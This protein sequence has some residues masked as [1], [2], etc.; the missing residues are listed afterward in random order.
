MITVRDLSPDDLPA[1]TAIYEHHTLH[2][3]GTFDEAPLSLDDM[4]G[5]AEK[6]RTQELPWLVAEE[7]GEIAG[8]AYAMLMHD[9][10]CWRFT[11]ENS[12]YVAHGKQRQG[13][14]RM[15]LSEL[16]SRCEALGYRQMIAAIGDSGNQGSIGLHFEM[17]FEFAGIYRAV[18]FKFG[19]WL[20][21]ILMQRALGEGAQ[22]RPESST[23]PEKAS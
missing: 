2:G 15:L 23:T 19:R 4:Q 11:L 6:V 5:R 9:R 22:T 8:Y 12:V 18:G 21:V 16:I 20:D 10:L 7:D 17:G 14:G 13:I 3:T 1:L